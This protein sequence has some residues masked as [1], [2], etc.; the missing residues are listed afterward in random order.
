MA[1]VNPNALATCRLACSWSL[2]L[3]APED[4]DASSRVSHGFRFRSAVLSV[5]GSAASWSGMSLIP[6][7]GAPV[8]I[9][10]ASSANVGG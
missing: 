5:G 1:V 6:G 7:T 3:S 10:W 2:V 8:A 9:S 4:D